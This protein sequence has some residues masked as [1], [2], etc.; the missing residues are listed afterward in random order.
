MYFSLL[1][2]NWQI[3][4]TFIFHLKKCKAMVWDDLLTCPPPLLWVCYMNSPWL[5]SFQCNSTKKKVNFLFVWLHLS[6]SE[7]NGNIFDFSVEELENQERTGS[8]LRSSSSGISHVAE[9]CLGRRAGCQ[10]WSVHWAKAVDMLE[11]QPS[12]QKENIQV[13]DLLQDSQG[14]SPILC[15]GDTEFWPSL[16]TA[17]LLK[18][19]DHR[20]PCPSPPQTS[21]SL[22]CH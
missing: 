22:T 2:N 7:K 1:T 6:H 8:F 3:C 14:Q 15:F 21:A 11:E 4:L 17:H 13:T 18:S 12:A 5:L 16:Q 9:Q 19:T 10:G 20:S